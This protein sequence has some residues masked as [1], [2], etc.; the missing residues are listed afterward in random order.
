ME[1]IRLSHDTF[2]QIEVDGNM[3]HEESET[4]E[5]AVNDEDTR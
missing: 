4:R 2:L 5:D 3:K 1:M